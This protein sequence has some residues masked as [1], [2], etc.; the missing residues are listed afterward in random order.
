MD[1]VKTS[2]NQA[3]SS[4][5]DS[6][7]QIMTLN[8]QNTLLLEYERGYECDGAQY[9]LSFILHDNRIYVFERAVPVGR[10]IDLESS[11]V[12]ELETTNGGENISEDVKKDR[13]KKS[14]E[15]LTTK[16][17]IEGVGPSLESNSIPS[18]FSLISED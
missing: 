3:S 9:I 18:S 5:V 14:D 4:F 15:H 17:I 2:Y 8:N 11:Q 12:F 6:A 10:S 16:K 7:R 1:L 13:P